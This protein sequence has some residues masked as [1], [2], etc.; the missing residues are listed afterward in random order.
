MSVHA[1]TQKKNDN[2]LKP[3][4]RTAADVTGPTHRTLP[5]F[6][7]SPPR[8]SLI[9]FLRP[10]R[11]A[12]DPTHLRTCAQQETSSRVPYQVPTCAQCARSLSFWCLRSR[13]FPGLGA[14]SVPGASRASRASSAHFYLMIFHR[15]HR[16]M[17]RRGY[18]PE[19][20]MAS[21]AHSEFPTHVPRRS[22][23]A[24][25]FSSSASRYA[26]WLEIGAGRM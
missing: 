14:G 5:C 11:P 23:L 25:A 2:N 9:S 18:L 17:A 21:L 19:V 24:A 10:C 20:R 7:R 13:S 15:H 16:S 26:L 22:Q 8:L 6:F 12:F 4:R 1:V 3:V